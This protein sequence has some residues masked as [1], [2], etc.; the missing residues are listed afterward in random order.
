MYTPIVYDL[1]NVILYVGDS[2]TIEEN[3]IIDF[4]FNINKILKQIKNLN[5]IDIKD[6]IFINIDSLNE[7]CFDL[8]GTYIYDKEK[9]DFLYKK[10]KP[11][12]IPN[13][14]INDDI[15]KNLQKYV[16]KTHL[17][18]KGRYIDNVVNI[19]NFRVKIGFIINNINIIIKKLNIDISYEDTY[20]LSSNFNINNDLYNANNDKNNEHLTYNDF[21][22]KNADNFIDSD[23]ES[24]DHN[25]NKLSID[26]NTSC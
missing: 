26:S 5:L 23:E 3:F 18:K 25:G 16:P 19:H 4:E 10:F 20:W 7:N 12:N 13:N 8:T 9:K 2:F 6:R 15:F 24:I 17:S 1:N 21:I 22:I 14:I 11:D